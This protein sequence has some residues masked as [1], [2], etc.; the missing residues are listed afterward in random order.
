[1]ILFVKI[2]FVIAIVF[3]VARANATTRFCARQSQRLREI[4]LEEKRGHSAPLWLQNLVFHKVRKYKHIRRSVLVDQIPQAEES[5]LDEVL[6]YLKIQGLIREHQALHPKLK[7]YTIT[8]EG[9]S[10]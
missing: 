2:L 7:T 5:D 9:L 10:Q 4:F 6:T 1:M 8:L 3:G